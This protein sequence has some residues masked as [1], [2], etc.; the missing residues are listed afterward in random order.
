MYQAT[1]PR[2]RR[3]HGPAAT[4]KLAMFQL[5][6]FGAGHASQWSRT[7]GRPVIDLR[8]FIPSPPEIPPDS[9][10]EE[11]LILVFGGTLVSTA[12]SRAYSEIFDGILPVLRKMFAPGAF[13]LRLVG[14]CPPVLRK[15]AEDCNDIRIT[16]RV[17]SFEA[18]LAKGRKSGLFTT[19]GNV[20]ALIRANEEIKASL[21]RSQV[22]PR[23][24]A[25]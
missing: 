25:R 16:G 12:S 22:L 7:L 17:P 2:Q 10:T 5:A 19:L 8:P 18:E 9:T 1:P 6:M 20:K 15:L 14:N 21:A 3:S 11:K 13:E 4:A 24:P 23:S